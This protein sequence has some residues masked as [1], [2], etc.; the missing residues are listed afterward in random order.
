M[1]TD[2][3]ERRIAPKGAIWVCAAC[4]K[5]SVDRY[6]DPDSLW[7]EICMLNAVLCHE[8]KKF[9]KEGVYCWHTFDAGAI[10]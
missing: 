6:G 9:N 10:P 5:T 3:R 2:S 1:T 4:G 7:D 8:Q